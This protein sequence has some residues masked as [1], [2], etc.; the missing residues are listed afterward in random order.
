MTPTHAATD[1]FAKL[2]AGQASQLVQDIALI[3][4]HHGVVTSQ[5]GSN[6][7][8]ARFAG[9]EKGCLQ[10]FSA[11]EIARDANEAER[12]EHRWQTARLGVFIEHEG[13]KTRLFDAICTDREALHDAHPAAGLAT[14]PFI[15]G[16]YQPGPWSDALHQ[17]AGG[18]RRMNTIT[19]QNFNE[20]QR[21]IRHHAP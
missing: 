21:P 13:K 4:E 12:S 9:G 10:I 18:L 11:L 6:I 5:H 20:K 8:S 3:M 19:A 14:I 16:P 7:S 2:Q 17:L 1:P 15:S